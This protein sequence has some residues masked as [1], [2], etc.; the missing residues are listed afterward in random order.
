ME[1]QVAKKRNS[2]GT[3]FQA[4]DG[5][6]LYPWFFTSQL[7]IIYFAIFRSKNLSL[8]SLPLAVLK[9]ENRANLNIGPSKTSQRQVL[10]KEKEKKKSKFKFKKKNPT[11]KEKKISGLYALSFYECYVRNLK[12]LME[13]KFWC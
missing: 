11:R 9:L 12:S 6:W 3:I 4:W 13:I 2:E 10:L 7:G 8:L 1:V 5:I